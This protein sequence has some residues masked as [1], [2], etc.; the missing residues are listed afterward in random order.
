M[1]SGTDRTRGDRQGCLWDVQGRH[2]RAYSAA[3]DGAWCLRHHCNSVAPGPASTPLT[4]KIYTPDAKRTFE[5]TITAKRLGTV[6]D[7]ASAIAFLASEA[8]DYINDVMLA[9]D[10]GY[11]AAGVCVTAGLQS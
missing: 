8:A 9:V 5:N 11:L 2:R 10:R 3:R 4:E 1:P 7:V 6:G